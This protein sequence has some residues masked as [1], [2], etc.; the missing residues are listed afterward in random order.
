MPVFQWRDSYS[1]GVRQLDNEHRRL[2]ELAN[3]M[4]D[5]MYATKGPDVLGRILT[6]LV[7]YTRTHLNNEERILQTYGYPDFPA[8]K[9][10][11]DDL[12]A[13]VEE[14]VERT[15]G[16]EGEVFIEVARFIGDWLRGHI[17]SVDR[18]YG[19]FLNE[20]GLE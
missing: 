15:K 17:Q 19:G 4:Y 9:R 18:K 12:T 8:H 7:D 5:A 14:Y 20:K 6:E 11:H 3:Q 13:K 16:G 1:V 2:F 10:V